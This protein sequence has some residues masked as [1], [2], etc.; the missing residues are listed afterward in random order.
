[1]TINRRRFVT[2][3]VS[4]LAMAGWPKTAFARPITWQGVVLGADAKLVIAGLPEQE[5]NRLI[6]I[7]LDEIERLENIFSI[8]RSHSDLSRLNKLGRLKNPKAEMLSL[9]S[10]VGTIYTASNGLFDPTIQ[11]LWAAYAENEGNPSKELLDDRLSLVD[12]NALN[13]SSQVIEFGKPEMAITLNGIAQGFVTDQIVHLLKAEGLENS[14]VKMGEISTIGKDPRGK[15]WE[16]GIA[17]SGNDVAEQTVRMTDQSI[18]TSSVDGTTFDGVT[19]HILD[20]RNGLSAKS[21][22]QRVSII[23]KSATLADGLSTAAILMNR[24]EQEAMARHFTEVKIISK[25]NYGRFY[26][27]QS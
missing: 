8:Y 18:A 12:W 7:A 22:W 6:R 17:K 4:A 23:H 5:A 3:S 10:T 20:P 27:R 9:F 14:I 21:D 16:I 13:I 26:A 25:D 19:S 2:I 24:D 1:M 11:P 15:A